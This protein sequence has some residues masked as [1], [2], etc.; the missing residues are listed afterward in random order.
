MVTARNSPPE[1]D[2]QMLIV[3][4]DRFTWEKNRTF[5][6]FHITKKMIG[7]TPTMGL[8]RDE[9]SRSRYLNAVTPVIYAKSRWS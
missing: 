5:D 8:K 9:A 4:P 6:K 3:Q 7:Y 1:W 2:T